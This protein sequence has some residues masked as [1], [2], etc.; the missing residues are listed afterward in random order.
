M[1]GDPTVDDRVDIAGGHTVAIAAGPKAIAEVSQNRVAAFVGRNDE[2]GA[3]GGPTGAGGGLGK[4]GADAAAYK[5]AVAQILQLR[6]GGG[7]DA[8]TKRAAPAK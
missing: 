7:A 2:E 1:A 8:S 6:G 4:V 3:A 5:A